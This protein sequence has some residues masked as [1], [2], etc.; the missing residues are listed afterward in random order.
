MNYVLCYSAY[1]MTFS[2]ITLLN[3]F[4]HAD[5]YDNDTQYNNTQHID[6]LSIRTQY[7]SIMMLP[8]IAAL[9]KYNGTQS[10]DTQ[11]NGFQNEDTYNKATQYNNTQHNDFLT[12]RTQL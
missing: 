2:L 8:N 10:N 5:A 7:P 1:A 11:L 3:D 4:Q 9:I 6:F 12:I